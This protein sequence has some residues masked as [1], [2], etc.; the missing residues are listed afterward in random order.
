MKKEVIGSKK[1]MCPC[2]MEEHDVK[3]V[4]VLDHVTFKDVLVDYNAIYNYCDRAEEFYANDDQISKNDISLK[5][6]YRKK[7]GLLTSDDIIKIRLKYDISQSDLCVLLG[8]GAKTIARY[9]THQVQSKSHDTIL[10]KINNDPEWFLKLLAESKNNFTA[11]AYEKYFDKASSLYENEQDIYLRKF[12]ESKYAIYQNNNMAQGNTPLSLDKVVDVIRY[13]A[14]SKNVTS[15]YKVKLMKLLWYADALSY[16]RRGHSI[17]GLV[18]Q[19]MPMGAVPIAHK[20]IIELKGVP[21]EEKEL[22]EGLAY[23]FNLSNESTFPSLTAE[24]KEILDVVIDNLGKMNK[25]AIVKFMHM[26][27][28]YTDTPDRGIVQFK[29]A[30]TLQIN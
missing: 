19:A 1:C 3:I 20:S 26:E 16:K 22:D 9:E 14:A 7:I 8:W 18:Y 24:D 5:N 29:Y 13:Y 12:I 2:C 23:Y 17:T 25:D 4:E 6:A 11:D 27:K 15:L 28:A 21:C 30:N 10:E